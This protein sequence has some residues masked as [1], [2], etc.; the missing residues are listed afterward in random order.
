VRRAGASAEGDVG[1]H[2]IPDGPCQMSE[3]CS[4]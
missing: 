1:K 3:R 2:L 4:F